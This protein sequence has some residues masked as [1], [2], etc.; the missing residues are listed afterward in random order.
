M[1][2]LLL[3]LSFV[4]TSCDK[5]DTADNNHDGLLDRQ[6]FSVLMKDLKDSIEPFLLIPSADGSLTTS[7]T[8]TSTTFSIQNLFNSFS[9]TQISFAEDF[10]SGIINSLVVIW[11]TE[12]G[13]KTFFIAAVLAMRNG[14][15]IVYLGCMTALAVMHIL[16]CLMG[17]ALPALLPK[18]YTHYASAVS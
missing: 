17:Y 7:T 12:I 11:V 6:E 2:F 14:R 3:F 1:K 5:F 10:I 18:V 9:F 16:S 4:I 13:D 8:T 15:T